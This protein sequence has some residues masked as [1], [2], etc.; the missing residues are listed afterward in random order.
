MFLDDMP[1][2]ISILIAHNGYSTYNTFFDSCHKV[3]PLYILVHDYQYF[4]HYQKLRDNHLC[5]IDDHSCS[6]ISLHRP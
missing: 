3:T 5:V 6:V 4:L 2:D 1:E